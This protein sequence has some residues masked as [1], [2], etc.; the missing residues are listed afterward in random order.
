MTA[1]SAPTT[2]ANAQYTNDNAFETAILNSTNTYRTQH[3]ATALTWNTTL[4]TYATTYASKCNWA[5]SGGPSGENLAEEY[6]N[7]TDAV[8]GWGDERNKYNFNNGGFSEAT[9]HFT[10]L[11]WK[12]T[13]SVG[14]GRMD[15]DGKGGSAQGWFVVCE[16][17]PA[18]NVQG[19]YGQEVGRE[20][21]TFVVKGAGEAEGTVR[22]LVQKM[23][24]VERRRGS[25]WGVGI[26]GVGMLVGMVS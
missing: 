18:G 26:V 21:R 24:G 10:Q 25:W 12:A 9:G 15:C 1:S 14:C 22:Y 4:A 20:V 11:V 8:D 7:V 16:Y 19:D 23:N 17:Y 5:H 6:A 2:T 3:N 13:T